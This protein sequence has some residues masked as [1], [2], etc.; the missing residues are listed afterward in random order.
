MK[1]A[2]PLSQSGYRLKRRYQLML[3]IVIVLTAYYPANFG[4][5]C[6]VDDVEMVESLQELSGWSFQGVFV[7]KMREGLYY[8][9]VL[10]LSFLFDSFVWNLNEHLM[11]LENL[12]LHGINALLVYWFVFQLLPKGKRERSLIPL[13]AAFLFGLHPINAESVNWISGRTDILAATFTLL[14]ANFLMLFRRHHEYRYLLASGFFMLSGFLTKEVAIAFLPGAFL[15]MAAH[16][17]VKIENSVSAGSVINHSRRKRV[18]VPI[19]LLGVLSFFFLLRSAAIMAN[20]GRIGTTIKVIFL[21]LSHS[22][23]VFLKAF[24]FYIK[25]LFLPF[26]LNF[27]IVEVDP[28]YEI[29]AVPLVLLCIYLLSKRNLVSAVFLA[30]VFLITPAFLIALEQIAWTPYAER[31]LYLPAAFI[32]AGSVLYAAILLKKVPYLYARK[33]IFVAILL[34]V[35]MVAT[36]YRSVIWMSNVTLFKD[37]VEKN[38]TFYL[39]KS[40]YA[41]ALAKRGDIQNARLQF[42]SAKEYNK[43]KIRFNTANPIQ[44]LKYWETPELGLANLLEREGKVE[45][46]AAAYEKIFQESKERSLPPLYRLLYR[47]RDVLSRTND[48]AQAVRIKKK[49]SIYSEKL[50]NMNGNPYPFYWIGKTLLM[51]GDKK[52]AIG[53]FTK[54]YE[55]FDGDDA[56]KSIAKKFIET[57]EKK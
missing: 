49:L 40:E 57:L 54:A 14:S 56:Y 1:F 43:T 4:E 29:L 22:G 15:L 46:A 35:M 13:T 31:Y 55:R 42:N 27:T 23:F 53:Y 44:K 37:A 45:E 48:P 17:H 32:T 11:H 2:F 5:L 50:Y 39:A 24:G 47:Y 26:P 12:L 41:F 51:R 30:G 8:R 34:A 33:G 10:I 7:P 38:P 20:E 21:D 9:P 36:F 18:F 16:D 25:K 6:S 52:E 3:L 28:L 19:L